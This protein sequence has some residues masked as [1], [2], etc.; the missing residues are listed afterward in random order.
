[1]NLQQNILQVLAY[2]DVFHYPLLAEEIASYLQQ[3]VTTAVINNELENLQ[4]QNR[5][6]RLDNFYSLRDDVF[7]AIRRKNG[8]LL[9]A[10]EMKKAARS[11]S[12]LYQ[13]PFVKG[14]AISGS[15]SKNY[16]DENTDIDFF[17]ITA[18]NRVWIARTLMHIFY[19]WA[20]LT[21]KQ[22]LYCMNYYI[23]EEALLIPEQNIFTAMEIITLIPVKGEAVVADFVRT[24]K[25]VKTY[26]PNETVKPIIS[27][28]NKKGFI[29][30]VTEFFLQGK[31]GNKID[32]WLYKLTAWHWQQNR[33][34]QKLNNK[35]VLTSMLAEKQFA[36]P[37]PKNFQQK[38][39]QQYEAKINELNNGIQTKP[40][41]VKQFSFA[42]K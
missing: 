12:V 27:L 3:P 13:F 30:R 14:L 28:E 8:N 42:G 15:L 38:I 5:I 11:A 41:V 37:D 6:Y 2:F 40:Y 31:T 29:R 34:Q 17:I 24:N 16:A 36:K 33:Q 18:P 1:M 39:L 10:Q 25:W 22:R 35:G 9:A 23:S 7:L 26:F 21:K 19:K 20:V 4:Q 32:N